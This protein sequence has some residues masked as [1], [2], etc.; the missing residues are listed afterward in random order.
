MNQYVCGFAFSSQDPVEVLLIHK[1]RPEWQQGKLNGIGG[2]I[3]FGEGPHEAMVREFREETGAEIRYWNSFCTL[4]DRRGW[5]VFFYMTQ[6]VPVGV[7]S[8]TDEKIQWV[9]FN[10]LPYNVVPNL[11][12]LLP[13]A[14][15]GQHDW[16]LQIT[17]TK[18]VPG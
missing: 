17:E 1:Q 7:R 16:P 11:H 9:R 8:M 14:W 10:R 15:Y 13:L 4:D 2:H 5:R 3:E 6:I 18:G 12:W